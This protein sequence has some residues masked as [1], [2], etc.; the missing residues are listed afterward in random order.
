MAGK[1]TYK[2]K[3]CGDPFEARVADRK[4]GWALYCS[5][6]C[7]AIEQTRRMGG[8]GGVDR[9]TYRRY[10]NEYGGIPEF[11]SNGDYVG[12]QDGAFDNTAHQNHDRD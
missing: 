7:K 1:A 11:D 2:C 3:T 5:K 10:A 9:E 4:R 8:R 12:F 6:S